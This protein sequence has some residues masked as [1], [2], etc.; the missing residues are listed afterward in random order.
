MANEEKIARRQGSVAS[1]PPPV[2]HTAK[3]ELRSDPEPDP[4]TVTE[5]DNDLQRIDADDLSNEIG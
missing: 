3:A 5:P 4:V 2:R 1:T